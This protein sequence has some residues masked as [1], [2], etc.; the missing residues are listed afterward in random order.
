MQG[1]FSIMIV[2]KAFDV[3]KLSYI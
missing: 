1:F 3:S 2:K